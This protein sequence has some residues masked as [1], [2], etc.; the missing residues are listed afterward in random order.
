MIDSW[1]LLYG[2]H[3]KTG[4]FYVHDINRFRSVDMVLIKIRL[5][6]QNGTQHIQEKLLQVQN[7][8]DMVKNHGEEEVKPKSIAMSLMLYLPITISCLNRQFLWIL[9]KESVGK[10]NKFVFI[11]RNLSITSPPY[12]GPTKQIFWQDYFIDSY[13]T[14][15]VANWF[16]RVAPE[17]LGS[18][19][20]ETN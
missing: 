6:L 18:N 7:M 17:V 16:T 20:R 9:V 3:Y 11:L 8:M 19:P 13:T 1:Y 15:S 10:K 4:Y 12:S 2:Y 5:L 14:A